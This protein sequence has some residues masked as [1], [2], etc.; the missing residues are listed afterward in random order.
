M[1]K[2]INASLK[3]YCGFGCGGST[4]LLIEVETKKEL[5]EI[6]HSAKK[7]WHIIGDGYNTLISDN[8][9]RGVVLKLCGEFNEIK[10]HDGITAGAGASLKEI[11]RVSSNAGYGGFEFL[12]GIPGTVG[13]AIYGNAG[14]MSA[15]GGMGHSISDVIK[16]VEIFDT[17]TE[18]FSILKVKELGF[19]YRSSNIGKEKIITECVFD[20]KS[21]NKSNII[22]NIALKKKKQ[23]MEFKSCGCVFK[24]LDGGVMSAAKI[25]EKAGLKGMKIGGASVSNLHANFLIVDDR[26]VSSKDIWRLICKIRET[27]KKKFNIELE[28]EINLLGEGFEL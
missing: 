11:L 20:L 2:T 15:A 23:P 3:K 5:K 9:V 13:G 28:L 17:N 25:I 14:G 1:K 27:V 12:A 8:G 10:I 6:I 7:K 22:K 19:S 21:S 26:N 16:E 4:A 18:I 24:N